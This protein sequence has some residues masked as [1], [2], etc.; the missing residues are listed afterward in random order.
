MTYYDSTNANLKYSKY[1]G[2]FW[3]PA[4]PIAETGGV[5]TYS[6]LAIDSNDNP[7]VTY[8]DSTNKNI[9][10]TKYDGSWSTAVSIDETV[11]GMDF[12]LAIDS[13]DNLHV[14]YYDSSNA[15]LKYGYFPK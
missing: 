2:S 3:S 15:D 5:G 8:Y 9:K 12:S 1:D 13:K 4:V 7:H 10:Y 11:S 14:T 6:S